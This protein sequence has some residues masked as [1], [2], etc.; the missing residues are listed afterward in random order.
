MAYDLVAK[1][2]LIDNLSEPMRRATSS[3]KA[4][5]KATDTYRNAQG[6][7]GNAQGKFIKDNNNLGMSLGGLV[8]KFKSLAVPIVGLAGAYGAVALAKSSLDKA[9]DFEAQL[10]SIK[11]LT[12]ATNDQ[13]KQMEDLALTMGSKTKYSALEAAQGIEELLKAGLTPAAVKAGGLEAALNLATA[14]GLDLAAAAE[15]MS[16]ALNAYKKDAMTA[17]EA[18][19]ILAGTANASATS[20]DEIRQSLAAVSAVAAGIGMNFKDTN[21]AL[22]L[23]ANNGFKGSDAGTSLKTMLQNLQP[24]TKDQIALFNRLGITTKGTANTFFTAQGKLQ[25]LGKISGILRKSLGGLTDMQRQLALETMFGT[26]AVRAATIL[27]NEGADGVSKFYNEMGNVSA[28]QVATEKMNNGR[29][30]I[31]QFKGALETLQIRALKPL[32]PAVKYAFNGMGDYIT[33]KTP[34]ITAAI[35]RMASTAKKYLKTHFLDNPE[36]N[37]IPDIS[38]KIKF[39]FDDLMATYNKWYSSTGSDAINNVTDKLVSSL[40]SAIEASAGPLASAGMKVGAAIGEGLWNGLQE[41]LAKYPVLT[42]LVAGVAGFRVAGPLGSAAA[43]ITAGTASAV[44]QYNE[45]KAGKGGGKNSSDMQS[46]IDSVNNVYQVPAGYNVKTPFD[47]AKN[48]PFAASGQTPPRKAGGLS[49]VPANNWPAYLDKGERVLTK[50]E[51]DGYSSG[52]S[53]SRHNGPLVH[54]ENLHVRNES[55]IDRI[56]GELARKMNGYGAVAFGG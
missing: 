22:G 40:A 4:A 1:L 32:L 9:L 26:D 41:T 2:K 30:A 23:F 53:G 8:G 44:A 36:F 12:G 55:D 18:S 6:R 17:A 25:S 14:G 35:E 27:Y 50:S 51:N 52:G 49:Y 20:V 46:L 48:N 33:N 29:G 31:E 39:I 28:L 43:I 15:T 24:T 56:A 13:M 19:D 45:T 54:V 7:L 38:G 11:A 5:E 42:M 16:T 47:I 37:K 3:I 34:Q 10:S 21:T